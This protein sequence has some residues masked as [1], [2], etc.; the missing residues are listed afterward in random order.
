MPDYNQE[1]ILLNWN[2]RRE[3]RKADFME[4]LFDVYKPSN[5]CYTGLWQKFCMGEA[6]PYCMHMYYEQLEALQ[7][8]L[9]TVKTKENI[10][11]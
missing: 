10:D 8:Y 6:G 1:E 11:V 7:K 3:Q 9:E 5:N 4:H 2:V